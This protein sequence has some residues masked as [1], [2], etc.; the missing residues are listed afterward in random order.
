MLTLISILVLLI[1]GL[2]IAH[3]IK[4][5]RRIARINRIQE[6]LDKHRASLAQLDSR[7]T[8]VLMKL[9]NK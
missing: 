1:I 4:D 5:F 6:N 7:L 9:G 8:A 2:K 3:K